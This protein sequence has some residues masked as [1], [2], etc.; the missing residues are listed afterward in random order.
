MK[1]DTTLSIVGVLGFV[2]SLVNL[3]VIIRSRFVRI[4][5]GDIVLTTFADL[6]VLDFACINNSGLSISMVSFEL[7][8]WENDEKYIER[9]KSTT[10]SVLRYRIDET[11]QKIRVST[12]LPFPLAPYEA[13]RFVVQFRHQPQSSVLDEVNACSFDN[14][15]TK[16]EGI[17]LKSFYSLSA[18]TSRKKEPVMLDVSVRYV[19]FEVWITTAKEIP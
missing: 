11:N 4:S 2:V 13:R 1:I 10:E 17:Q 18:H 5:V 19:P 15:R 9:L 16:R 6:I 8:R 3:V 14:G 12:L 7:I